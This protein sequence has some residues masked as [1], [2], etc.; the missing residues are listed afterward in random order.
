MV[1]EEIYGGLTGGESVHLTDWPDPDSEDLPDDPA[2]VARMDRLRDVASTALRLREDASLRVRLP[3][4]AATVAG[5][6]AEDLGPVVDLLRDE[7]NVKVVELTDT[8]EGHATFVLRPDGKRLGPRLGQDVQAVFAAARSGDW[9]RADDGTV[10]VAGHTL[11]PDEYELALQASDGAA[12][13]ALRSNDAVVV[14]DTELTPELESEGLARDVVR[15]V[16]N[17]RKDDDLVVTDRIEISIEAASDSVR[18]AIERWSDY[19][20]EQ[21]LAVSLELGDGGGPDRSP[22]DGGGRH[23]TELDGAPFTFALRVSPATMAR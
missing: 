7:I 23:E 5:A 6:G 1:A 22:G 8:I 11:E 3:L 21:V 19:V 14:L 17:A 16:Q 13:A 10:T 20:A 18:A 4:T 2:L 15:L 12:A 9:T